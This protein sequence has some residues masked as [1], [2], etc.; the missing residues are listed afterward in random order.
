MPEQTHTRKYSIER[1]NAQNIV[2]QFAHRTKT[3][4]IPGKP[5][6]VNQDS[7][8]ALVNYT[9]HP[10]TYLF[11]V[12][13]GHGY[14]GREVSQFVK[15]RL[16]EI[17]ARDCNNPRRNLTM[18]TMLCHQELTR[19]GIDVNF[20]GTT[21]TLVYMK[22][23]TLWCANAGDSRSVIARQAS[24][25]DSK[26]SG[27][28]WMAIALSRDHKPDDRE[29]SARILAKGGRIEAYQGKL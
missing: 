22:D 21:M 5:D 13:D 9:G 20:S 10:Q 12:C 28:H 8:I 17:L 25:T 16:P 29:E 19:S 14:Y 26:S 4:F 7:L 2:A 11:S 6:K 18:A 27:K 1:A 3:G 23:S 15:Q 24:S